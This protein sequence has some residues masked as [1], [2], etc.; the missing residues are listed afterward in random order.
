MREIELMECLPETSEG[1][2]GSLLK[3]VSVIKTILT[4]ALG[5]EI[6]VHEKLKL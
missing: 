3:I 1:D 4:F 2:I 6:H 5:L